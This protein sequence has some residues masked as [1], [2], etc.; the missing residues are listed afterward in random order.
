M[1]T[2]P[3]FESDFDCLTD[4]M[5][6]SLIVLN[7]SLVTAIEDCYKL[8]GVDKKAETKKIKSA[9]RKMAEKLQELAWCDEV[10]TDK[11]KRKLYD[12]CGEKCVKEQGEQGGDASPFGGG[13]GGF[14][15]MFGSMFGFGDQEEEHRKGDLVVV[16]LMVTLGELYNGAMIDMLRTKRTYVETGGT[17]QCNCRMEMKQKRMG[18][19][20]FTI[21]QEKVCEE[22]PN[23]K[24]ESSDEE[25]EIEIE[26]GMDHGH[27]INYYGEGEPMIDGEAGDLM[28]KLRLQPHAVFERR[29]ND[30]YTNLTISLQDALTGFETEITH[31]DGHKVRVARASTTWHGF[32]MRIKKEGMPLHHDNTQFGSLIITMDVAFPKTDFS[33]EQKKMIMEL[34]QQDNV[35]PDFYNG[36]KFPKKNK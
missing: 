10:L 29:G 17:R 14:G 9:Y 15:S 13:F 5:K 1:G 12:K 28:V 20:Q 23:V 21:Y 26:R 30:L 33:P 34:L 3:I 19:G 2:H 35:K 36:L 16:P 11:D 32:K 24:L 25:L 4:K 8:I 18:M 7:L 6:L 27:E 31:L 22:C